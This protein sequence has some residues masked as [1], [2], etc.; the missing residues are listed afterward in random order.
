MDR[1]EA[2]DRTRSAFLLT[3]PP[4]SADLY[5][6]WLN[7]ADSHEQVR[8]GQNGSIIYIATTAPWF[9]WIGVGVISHD[10]LAPLLMFKNVVPVLEVWDE[11]DLDG[12]QDLVPRNIPRHVRVRMDEQLLIRNPGLRGLLERLHG[13]SDSAGGN[14]ISLSPPNEVYQ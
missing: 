8:G 1:V 2:T 10:T 11:P 5:R 3:L 14:V 9:F 6:A 4:R 13:H 12:G 7:G